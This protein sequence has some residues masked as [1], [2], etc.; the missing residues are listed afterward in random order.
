MYV[1]DVFISLNKCLMVF[2]YVFMT[3]GIIDVQVRPSCSFVINESGS[4]VDMRRSIIQQQYCISKL[5]LTPAANSS[6]H[7]GARKQG[8]KTRPT[9]KPEWFRTNTFNEFKHAYRYS[10]PESET[11]W[12]QRRQRLSKAFV[13]C[14]AAAAHAED[15]LLSP[16]E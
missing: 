4:V 12:A 8:G 7:S 13:A 5:H 16:D 6:S 10:L 11:A 2:Y 14:R 3:E 15:A 9:H 1:V